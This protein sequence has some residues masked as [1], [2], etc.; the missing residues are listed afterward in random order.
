M[1][2]RATITS[3]HGIVFIS[4]PASPW[5]LDPSEIGKW[6]VV[7]NKSCVS[8]CTIHPQQGET[9]IELATSI[10]QPIGKLVFEGELETPGLK[11]T[12]TGSDTVPILSMDVREQITPLKIWANDDRWPNY[13][14]ILAEVDWSDVL[15]YAKPASGEG[16][17]QST[18]E[19]LVEVAQ[20]LDLVEAQVRRITANIK[21][22]YQRGRIALSATTAIH[23]IQESIF[24]EIASEFPNLISNKSA[25]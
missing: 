9:T 23:D 25:E 24:G 13:I 20:K 2:L 19:Q 8:V 7:A 1:R 17:D 18:A 15:P 11:I 10:L 12:V 6:L 5:S 21:D 4:D 3:D 16:M 22:D 14:Q